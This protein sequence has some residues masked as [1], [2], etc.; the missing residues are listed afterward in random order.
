M[1]VAIVGAGWAG[2]AA[3]VELTHAGL[4]PTVFE[5][6]RSVG[7]RARTLAPLSSLS[8]VSPQSAPLDNGQHILI[9]A[10]RESLRLM[11]RVGVSP[12]AA[13][14]RLPLQ[15]CFTDGSG[16]QWPKSDAPPAWQALRAIASARG[17]TLR[18]KAALLYSAT[19]WGARGFNC[20]DTITV[21]Q[22]CA[23]LTQRLRDEFIDPLCVS[24]LNTPAHEASGRVF[25]RVLR[26]SLFGG[27]GS[28]DFLL[29]RTDLGA[30]FADSAAQW[31]RERGATLHTGTRVQRLE[32]LESAKPLSGAAQQRWRLEG[33]EFDAVLVATHSREALRLLCDLA[34]PG[35]LAT[36]QAL[37][38]EAITTVYAQVP[39]L[40][41][42][43]DVLPAPMLALRS[44]PGQPAQFVFDRG[45]LGGPA[46]LLAFVVSASEGTRRTLEGQ[47]LAQARTQLGLENLQAVQTVVEKHATFACTAGLQRPAAGALR[48]GLWA[49]GDYLDGPYPATLEGAVRSGCAGAAAVLQSAAA[50]AGAGTP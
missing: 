27:R 22:L 39:H 16:L 43:S 25:L 19:L 47:V 41:S 38:F 14:L 26:D 24:A 17:W 46:G 18:D 15:L 45:Q 11:R 6:A 44:P 48:A 36:A 10:Y 13:L 2:L 40:P 49:V 20:A 3:A 9:G 29:P 7:G 23:R 50:G 30:C 34:P 12:E 31:L 32:P 33:A 37:R 5:A 28:A 21:A 42:G 4:R 1:R 35:W 8:P